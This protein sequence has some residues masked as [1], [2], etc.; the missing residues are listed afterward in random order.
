MSD[1]HSNQFKLF[2]E[3]TALSVA[4]TWEEAKLEWDLKHVYREDVPQTCLCGHTPIIEICVL[5]NRLNGNFAD[6]GNV[7]VTKFLGLASDLIFSGLKR[8]SKDGN[9]ALNEA[10]IN[11]AF[12]QGWINEWEKTFCFNTMRK[13][14]LSIKQAAKRAEINQL[15]LAKTT[16][17]YKKR[18]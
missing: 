2:K 4:R 17:T 1:E 14:K 10:A 18:E 7:C 11:Y 5:Q 16:N 6:V 15:V 8:I 12:E 3:I 13:R 9:K